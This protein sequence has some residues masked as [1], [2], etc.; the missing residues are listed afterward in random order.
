[1]TISN[2]LK[3]EKYRKI[4]KYDNDVLCS[5]DKRDKTVARKGLET[6]RQSLLLKKNGEISLFLYFFLLLFF[7][8]YC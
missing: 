4:S 2:R 3:I 5:R 8:F 7:A 6:L 1:M